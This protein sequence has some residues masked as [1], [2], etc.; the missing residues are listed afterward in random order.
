MVRVQNL[1]RALPP[2]LPVFWVFWLPV[3]WLPVSCAQWLLPPLKVLSCS[4]EENGVFFNFSAAPQEE[5]ILKAFSMTEDGTRLEGRFAFNG[6][7]TRFYPVN[8]IREGRAYKV[9]LSTTAE[10]QRGNSLETDYHREFFT[11]S[12]GEAPRVVS[13]LPADG[14]VLVEAPEEIRLRFS[15]A[16]DP[17]SF[18]EALRISPAPSFVIQWEDD[19]REALIRPVRPL[20]MG[21]RYSITVSTALLDRSRN[22]MV[23]PFTSSFLL[24]DDRSPPEGGLEWSNGAESG[25]LIR[26]QPNRGLPPDAEFILSFSRDLAVESLGAY[27]E[28]Q[29]SL[30]LSI[31]AEGESRRLV[32]ISLTR[33]PAWGESHA[34]IIRRGIAADGSWESAE[35]LFFP[36]VFDSPRFIPPRFL[37]G[38]FDTG[39]EI[40]K[41][42]EGADFDSLFLDP[43]IFPPVTGGTTATELC[44]LFTVSQEAAAMSPAIAPASAMEGF[45]ISAGNGC[46]YISIKKLQVLNEASYRA[47]IFNDSGLAAGDGEELCA[48]IYGLEIENTQRQ[49]LIVFSIGST[50]KDRLGN[51][52]GRDINITWNKE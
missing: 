18:E 31:N 52:L 8:G 23:L 35:D 3:F 20:S 39:T 42:S 47:G 21:T 10:D 48:L 2:I 9:S 14:S 36:L 49:G 29:P 19:Y 22:A 7:E 51:S 25:P 37:G 32:R 12:E 6:T 28:I 44:L 24:G 26:N 50:L 30:G 46:A 4:L 15:E 40:K 11:R 13:V 16:V 43:V 5:S 17:V 33:K 41:M 34:L 45:S 38:F 27:I 1:L